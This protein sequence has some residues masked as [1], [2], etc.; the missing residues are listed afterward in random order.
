MH[1]TAAKDPKCRHCS[2]AAAVI[3]TY[4]PYLGARRDPSALLPLYVLAGVKVGAVTLTP[5]VMFS[6]CTSR[7][8]F[9]QTRFRSRGR[10]RAG[11]RD[12]IRLAIGSSK[13]YVVTHILTVNQLGDGS[14]GEHQVLLFWRS[15][16]VCVRRKSYRQ[17]S[18]RGNVLPVP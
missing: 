14:P 1:G 15:A 2:L 7:T 10:G 11:K 6:R 17:S 4:V 13:P 16:L 8:A 18:R 5:I 12:A 3:G 9:Q